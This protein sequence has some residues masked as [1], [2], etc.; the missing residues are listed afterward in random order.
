MVAGLTF[1]IVWFLEWRKAR[2][3]TSTPAKPLVSFTSVAA[4]CILFLASCSAK[5]EKIAY[6]K[7]QCDECRMTIMDPKFGGEIVT[8]K[9]RVYKFD[10]ARCLAK[11]LEDR[12]VALGDIHA[13]LFT[14]YLGGV[15]F[16]DTKTAVFVA[17]SQLKS[18]MNGNAAAFATKAEADKV[19]ADINGKLTDWSTLYNIIK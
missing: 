11:F 4:A 13:T 3:F 12:K 18:P 9:G 1:F 17:G 16:L 14:N 5:P 6:G 10:D 8:K 7:D 15:E 2:R 19:A